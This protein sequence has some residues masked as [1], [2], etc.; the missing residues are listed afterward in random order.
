MSDDIF[1]E[2]N[3]RLVFWDEMCD[4]GK[5]RTQYQTV[6][7]H[8]SRTPAA[9]IAQK[10]ALAGKLFMNRTLLLQCT[11]MKKALNGF[12]LSTLL[13]VRPLALCQSYE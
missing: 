10:E 3:V 1:S 13:P 8:L 7:D 2:C 9:T 6:Y 5:V 11:R 12:S 4:D